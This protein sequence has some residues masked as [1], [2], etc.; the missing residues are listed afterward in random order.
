MELTRSE[1]KQTFSK[2]EWITAGPTLTTAASKWYAFTPLQTAAGPRAGVE[3]SGRISNQPLASDRYGDSYSEVAA[4]RRSL[5][6]SGGSGDAN[7]RH[8]RK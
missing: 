6:N 2:L 5:Q 3:A 7:F 1:A 4:A 8:A